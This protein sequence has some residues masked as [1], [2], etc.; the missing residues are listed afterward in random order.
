MGYSGAGGK[1]IHEKNQKQKISWHGPFN[2]T[3]P[4]ECLSFVWFFFSSKKTSVSSVLEVAFSAFQTLWELAETRR[5]NNY[6]GPFRWQNGSLVYVVIRYN[7]TDMSS[8]AITPMKIRETYT[9]CYVSL[10]E[11][12]TDT[13]FFN[14][15]VYF[16]W[17]RKIIWVKTFPL[18]SPILPKKLERDSLARKLDRPGSFFKQYS[19]FTKSHEAVPL[20][21]ITSIQWRLTVL[22]S[23]TLSGGGGGGY[24][25]SHKVRK[26]KIPPPGN[27]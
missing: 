15:T 7:T 24:L 14:F 1:L 4:W 11:R 16:N 3:V 5:H 25:I 22:K 13:Y 10:T 12:K 21:Q 20:N 19:S 23:G 6:L 9:A 17:N 27:H 8:M 26:C 2:G 18:Q